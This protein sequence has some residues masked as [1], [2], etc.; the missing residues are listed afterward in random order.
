MTPH[1]GPATEQRRRL[2]GILHAVAA[3]AVFACVDA[4]AKLLTR[5]YPVTMI[6][7]ARYAFLVA[8]LVVALGPR[9]GLGL[10]RSRR[11]W[12]QLLRGVVLVS[13]SLMF[14]TALAHM[15]LAEA[16]AITFL[17]PVFVAI[18]AGPLLH[19]RVAAGNWIAI[20]LG[21][22]GVQL[23]VRPG[24]EVFSWWAILPVITAFAMSIYQILTRR[25]A[26]VDGSLVQLAFPAIIGAVVL[27]FIAP[28]IEYW[29]TR[30]LD[31]VL[32]ASLG[33]LGGLGHWLFIRG[34]QRAPAST[35]APFIY[36]QLVGTLA[37]GYLLFDELPDR[38]ATLGIA[39]IVV[40]GVIV[41]LQQRRP[42]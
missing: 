30:P 41:V 23:I 32:M 33:L 11:P 21:L 1:A 12:L 4:I 15:Q 34:F 8:L 42:G 29:P 31:F 39:I 27:S 7:W 38:W 20:M 5:D 19:E 35:L 16:S 14:F 25:L 18:L 28:V 9:H 36:S 37:L 2:S 40:S 6:V 17:A 13:S 3:L 10:V 24:T 26:A 22:A